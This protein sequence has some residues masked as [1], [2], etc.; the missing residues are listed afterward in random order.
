MLFS[1]SEL[2]NPAVA[3]M[4]TQAMVAKANQPQAQPP[5][6]IVQQ[7]R[8]LPVLDPGTGQEVAPVAQPITVQTTTDTYTPGQR[9]FING[10]KIGAVVAGASGVLYLI[11]RGV[12]KNQ[13]YNRTV[14]ASDDTGEPD[15]FANRIYDAFN[16]DTPFGW[17]TDEELVRD[18]ISDVPHRKFWEQVKGKYFDLTKRTSHLME[19]LEKEV[20]NHM[21]AEILAIIDSMPANQREANNRDPFQVTDRMLKNWAIRI[22]AGADYESTF[23]WP[24]GTDEEAIYK[25]LNEL[26]NFAAFCMLNGKYF[27]LYGKSAL[28]EL[29]DEMSGEDLEKAYR[30]LQSKE[31]AIGKSKLEL[32]RICT[33]GSSAIA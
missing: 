19:D 23:F 31:D 8:Q 22:K 10:L 33:N 17:G 29:S 24:Y 21:K 32:V 9:R 12:L 18:T 26:P 20:S 2:G 27:Q 7:P 28:T 25:V 14:N 6:V 16:P 15:W 30:I 4:V 11:L 1:N 5:T 13:Q 3:A